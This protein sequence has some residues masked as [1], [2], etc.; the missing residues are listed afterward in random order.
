LCHQFRRALLTLDGGLGD[1]TYVLDPGSTIAITDGGGNDKI[2]FSQEPNPQAITATVGTTS[3]T[4]MDADGLVTFAGTVEAVTGTN[5]A[6]TFVDHTSTTLL[7]SDR[8]RGDDT[9]LWHAGTT[10]A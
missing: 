3:T 7:S 1:D 4:A 2:D 8:A 6:D 5:Q 10:T 9:Y